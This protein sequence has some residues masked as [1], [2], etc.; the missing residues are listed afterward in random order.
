MA[1]FGVF[2]WEIRSDFRKQEGE[3][4][5]RQNRVTQR[6]VHAGCLSVSIIHR[7]LDTDYTIFNVRADVNACDCT[8]GCADPLRESALKVDCWREKKYF[9]APG[10]RTCSAACQS[11]ALPLELH[12]HQPS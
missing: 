11:D 2:P 1:P 3:S 8:Q 5:L 6:T 12:H 4:Q 7:T 9:A 10:N